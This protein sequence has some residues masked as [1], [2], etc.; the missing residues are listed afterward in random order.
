MQLILGTTPAIETDN[1]DDE[2]FL[3]STKTR[4]RYVQF[5]SVALHQRMHDESHSRKTKLGVFAIYTCLVITAGTLVV[6]LTA[7]KNTS[8]CAAESNGHYLIDE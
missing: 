4:S 5:F 2:E 8:K 3:D 7:K 1:N 6:C